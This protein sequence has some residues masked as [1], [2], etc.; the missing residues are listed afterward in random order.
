[1]DAIDA[2]LVEFSSDKLIKVVGYEE[3]TIEEKMKKKLEKSIN[4][5]SSSVK[6]ICELNVELGNCFS[7]AVKNLLEKSKFDSHQI[8]FIASRK[9]K[10]KK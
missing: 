5:L 4:P 8:S 2:V 10:I 1:M 3:T 9:N 6:D 7:L